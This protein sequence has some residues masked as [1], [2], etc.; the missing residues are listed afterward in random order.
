MPAITKTEFN[1]LTK[2]LRGLPV[3]KV[4]NS[5]GSAIYLKMGS[6][7]PLDASKPEQSLPHVGAIY[8]YWDWRLE[9]AATILC[10][11]SNRRSEIGGALAKLVGLTIVEFVLEPLLPDL[12]MVFSNG[13][14][15]RSMSLVAG[16]PTW[17][18]ALPDGGTIWGKQGRV[19]H[20][21]KPIPD[22]YHPDPMAARLGDMAM[23]ADLRWLPQRTKSDDGA[24]ETCQFFV[25]LDGPSAFLWYGACTCAGSPFDG[26]VVHQGSWCAEFCPA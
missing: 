1:Q 7:L 23:A 8:L 21:V 15:L 22:D 12:T 6:S 24:C 3:L 2:P 19:V 14:R 17:T 11:S 10:G 26:R 25:P 13:W 20:S 18:L 4:K 9:D 5:F 16:D